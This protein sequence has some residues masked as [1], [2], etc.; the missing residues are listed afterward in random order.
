MKTRKNCSDDIEYEFTNEC[1]I[2]ISS[3]TANTTYRIG[4]CVVIKTGR[5][6]CTSISVKTDSAGNHF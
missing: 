5:G 4:V 6:P 1:G 2:T 3:L